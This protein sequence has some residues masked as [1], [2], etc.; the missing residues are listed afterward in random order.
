MSVL[1]WLVVGHVSHTV[2]EV[3]WRLVLFWASSAWHHAA[4]EGTQCAL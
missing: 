4:E 1:F 2:L 3:L